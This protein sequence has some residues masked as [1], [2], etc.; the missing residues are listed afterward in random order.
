MYGAPFL[1]FHSPLEKTPHKA[2]VIGDGGTMSAA[3]AL[4]DMTAECRGAAAGNS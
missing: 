1:L 2:T 4:I 3:G